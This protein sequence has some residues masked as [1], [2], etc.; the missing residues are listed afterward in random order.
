MKRR[1]THPSL[2][3]WSLMA[4]ALI[5]VSLASQSIFAGSVT[6]PG[7]SPTQ[8]VSIYQG[9][10]TIAPGRDT[11]NI[12]EFGNNGS[13]I[14]SSGNIYFRPGRLAETSGVRFDGSSGTTDIYVPGRL[15]I[16][17]ACVPPWPS[18]S[19]TSLWQRNGSQLETVGAQPRGVE[20]LNPNTTYINGGSALSA[21][22]SMPGTS[23]AYFSN[24]SGPA[25]QLNDGG[26]VRGDLVLTTAN[27]SS[28]ITIN[29]LNAGVP[30]NGKVWYPGNDG[31]GSRLDA[32]LLDGHKVHFI[33]WNGSGYDGTCGD[34]GLNACGTRYGIDNQG[35]CTDSLNT[36]GYSCIGLR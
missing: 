5:G 35:I 36:Y 6:N 27:V 8:K 20:I 29:Y 33:F 9:V 12:L 32:D 31:M 14:T 11:N 10:L 7:G 19:G 15:C 30:T 25:L 2:L 4:L 16:N 23:A 22:G 34:V 18:G 13:D 24:T 17:G 1:A 26:F 28:P 3:R 21:V